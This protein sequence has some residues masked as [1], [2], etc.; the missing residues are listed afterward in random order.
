M[1]M[2]YSPKTAM[3]P[4]EIEKFLAGKHVIRVATIRKDGSPHVSP[5]WYYWDGA[6]LWLVLGRGAHPRAHI[7]NLRRDPRMEA[8]IDI[9]LRLTRGSNA[10]CKGVLLRGKVELSENP[11]LQREM[12]E[13]ILRKF[14]GSKGARF[15]NG[16]LADGA[17]GLNRVVVKMKPDIILGWDMRR[18]GGYAPS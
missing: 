11:K 12:T 2:T 6:Y 4:K 5:L 1:S 17:K 15:T 13:K 7:N 14:L 9:D 18:L 16:A 10:D 8:V 3:T